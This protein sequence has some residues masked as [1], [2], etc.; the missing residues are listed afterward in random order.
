MPNYNHGYHAGNHADV[1]KHICLI[2]FLKSIK[3]LDNSII[4]IDT[5]SGHGIYDLEEESMQKNKE[6]LNG[7]SKLHNL[8]TQD[9]YIRFY[10]KTIK[11][12]NKSSKIKFYPGSP[13][14]NSIFN[15]YKR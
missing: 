3:K 4:Y 14:N 5:H 15:K 6:Y 10:F 13:K 12:I 9:P 8:Q 7:F 11:N 2:Y 1:L